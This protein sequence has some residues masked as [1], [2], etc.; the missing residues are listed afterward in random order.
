M[1]SP[2]LWVIFLECQYFETA[3]LPS[4]D[5]SLPPFRGSNA[6]VLSVSVV[7]G[8]A[9]LDLG[10]SPYSGAIF[11]EVGWFACWVLNVIFQW[12]GS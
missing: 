5:L 11:H 12:Q 10:V 4:G 1:V 3:V 8:L 9:L 2:I 7:E 6:G